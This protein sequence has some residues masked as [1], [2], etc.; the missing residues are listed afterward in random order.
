MKILLEGTEEMAIPPPDAV[1][2]EVLLYICYRELNNVHVLEETIM[3][4]EVS[5]SYKLMNWATRISGEH[6]V[7]TSSPLTTIMEMFDV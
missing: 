7:L 1:L 3:T 2:A 4:V 6:T 5:K